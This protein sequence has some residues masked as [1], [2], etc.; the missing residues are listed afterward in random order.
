MSSLDHVIRSHACLHR[1]PLKIDLSKIL[2]CIYMVCV[3]VCVCARAC[4]GV[5]VCAC[6]CFQS[7]KTGQQAIA[8]Y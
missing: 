4:V 7:C 6:V 2:V 8:G 1:S 5:G 3:C